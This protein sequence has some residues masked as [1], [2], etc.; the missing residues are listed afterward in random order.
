MVRRL[1]D[2]DGPAGGDVL[3]PR[4]GVH[5]VARHAF[6]DLRSL[7]ERDDGLAGVDPDANGKLQAGLLDVGFLDV[8][9]D[10]QAGADGALGVVLMAHRGAEHAEH[11][12]ADELVDR[13]AEMLDRA[14]QQRVI[15][16]EHRLHVLGVRLIRAF[17]EPHQVAEQDRD[18]LPLL[19]HGNARE[20]RPAVQTETGALGVLRSASGADDHGVECIDGLAR[21]SPSADWGTKER[22]RM[23]DAHRCRPGLRLGRPGD[24]GSGP[25]TPIWCSKVEA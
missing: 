7:T 17:R 12:V 25:W 23:A 15:D 22:R 6:P 24:E 4:C 3:Q 16:A 5:D 19:A 2:H 21:H 18:D 20:R 1:T 9:Q 11:R 14:F 10:L 8:L 13:A